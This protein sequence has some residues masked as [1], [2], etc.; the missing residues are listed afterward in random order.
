[1]NQKPN[2]R[3][4]PA[5]L[6]DRIKVD[7]QAGRIGSSLLNKNEVIASVIQEI[8]LM[9]NARCTVRRRLYESHI[10][11]VLVYGMPD[12]LGLPDFSYFDAANEQDWAM[13]SKLLEI[14][15]SSIEPRM[16]TVKVKITNFDTKTQE[17]VVEVS[18]TVKSGPVTQDI[19][20][21]LSLSQNDYQGA[22]SKVA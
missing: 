9:L 13:A 19:R 7:P 12:M 16:Q 14:T 2:F 8:S 3:G 17:L 20:F 15:I 10:D 6:F 5:P 18:G 1:M 21:P 22:T 4:A 11:D